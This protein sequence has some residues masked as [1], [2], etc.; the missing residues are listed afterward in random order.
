LVRRERAQLTNGVIELRA[1]RC[2]VH[3]REL[4]RVRVEKSL[5]LAQ[6]PPCEG[7]ECLH[8]HLLKGLDAAESREIPRARVRSAGRLWRLGAKQRGSPDRSSILASRLLMIF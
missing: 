3:A 8:A 2:Y 7:D 1:R 6:T 4:A 5:H